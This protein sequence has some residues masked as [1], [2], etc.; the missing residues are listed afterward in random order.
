M[1]KA[2]G[3]VGGFVTASQKIIDYL[4]LYA[5]SNMYS[6]SLPPSVCA[7][8]VEV[9]KYMKT[10]NCVSRLQDN[11]RYV[12]E[13]LLNRGYN[14]MNTETGIIPIIVGDEHK[15]TMMSKDFLDKGI[16]VNYIFPPVVSPKLSRI[17][18]SIMASHTKDDL[19]RLINT[20]DTVFEIYS[21]K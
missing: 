10:S 4:R 16:I 7:S 17:R 12:R 2:L 15:L 14:I 9:F 20:I 1:R 13:A 18:I 21:L 8:A 5:R 3:T 19:D 6:T 11:S